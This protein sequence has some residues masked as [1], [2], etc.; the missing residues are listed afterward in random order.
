MKNHTSFIE[1]IMNS[2]YDGIYVTNEKGDTMWFNNAFLKISGI[3]AADLLEN[4][5]NQLLE[6][7]L[8]PNSCVINVLKTKEPYSTII[9]YV[10]GKKALVSANP[11]FDVEGNLMNVVANV[12]D[13]TELTDL[14]EKLEETIALN[15]LYE[16]VIDQSEAYSSGYFN[17]KGII[18]QSNAMEKIMSLSRKM[19]QVDTPVLILGESGVGKDV[20]ANYIHQISPRSGL[21]RFVKINCGAIPEQLLESELFGY[22]KGSFSG[23]LREGKK[24]LFEVAHNGTVFLDE[25]GEMPLHLQVKLL[26]V[27]QD[28]TFTRVGGTKPIPIDMRV[29][30]ATN[31]NLEEM[32]EQKR[33]RKDLYYRLNVLTIVIPPLKDR[34]EDILALIRE[35]LGFFNEKYQVQKKL[36]HSVFNTL[37]S[38]HW[39]GNV[40]ELRNLLERLVLISDTNEIGIHHLPPSLLSAQPKTE[41]AMLKI[42]QGIERYSS[43]KEMVEVF[44]RNIILQV[45]QQEPT[46]KKSAERLGIDISTLIRKKQKY[47]IR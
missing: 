31:A 5:V 46:L 41:A 17:E 16:S 25:I 43:L 45:L 10:N 39:P 21:G 19:A 29:I 4:N 9:D 28:R 11:I 40:R 47:S 32:I 37:L 24:G 35:Y 14:K 44:E 33:F 18:Y 22:E 26:N 20:L 8:I 3:K 1:Q 13:I 2:S 6:K 23:A 36:D 30:A 42:Q 38:Y 15:R 7:N 27:L 12:R 34:P